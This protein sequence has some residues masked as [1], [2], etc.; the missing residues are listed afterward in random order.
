MIVLFIFYADSISRRFLGGILV[1]FV[2][3]KLRNCTI[4]T[5]S[6]A[7]DDLVQPPLHFNQHVQRAVALLKVDACDRLTDTMIIYE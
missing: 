6:V 2:P 3:G 7:P 1:I 5:R 4:V